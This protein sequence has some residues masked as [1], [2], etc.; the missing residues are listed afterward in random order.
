M[1]QAETKIWTLNLLSHPGTP[2]R[3]FLNLPRQ[4]QTQNFLLVLWNNI[5]KY[6]NYVSYFLLIL[7]CSLSGSSEIFMFPLLRVGLLQPIRRTI[8]EA[9]FQFG[10]SW[11]NFETLRHRPPYSLGDFPLWESCFPGS[12]KSYREAMASMG[13]GCRLEELQEG[14][15]QSSLP[16]HSLGF[17]AMECLPEW[18]QWCRGGPRAWSWRTFPVE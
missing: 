10:V 9:M 1:T 3:P 4:K 6:Y 5:L 14:P 17:R 12:R 15:P 11:L 2:T 8:E 7:P 16:P 13:W 18:L